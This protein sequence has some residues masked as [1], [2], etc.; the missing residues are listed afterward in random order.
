MKT[1]PSALILVNRIVRKLKAKRPAAQ[2]YDVY[3]KRINALLSAAS[4]LLRSLPEES[5]TRKSASF[6]KAVE[7]VFAY[8]F[9]R[10]Y[11]DEYARELLPYIDNAEFVSNVVL[12]D[13]QLNYHGKGTWLTGAVLHQYYDKMSRID[14]KFELLHGSMSEWFET[15]SGNQQSEILLQRLNIPMGDLRKSSYNNAI[16][17]SGNI[18]REAV[19]Y[20]NEAAVLKL[21]AKRIE[22]IKIWRFFF[23]DEISFD[24]KSEEG[25]RLEKIAQ[26]FNP[27]RWIVHEISESNPEEERQCYGE[28]A[29]L[30]PLEYGIGQI[31]AYFGE[32]V[33]PQDEIRKLMAIALSEDDTEKAAFY[34]QFIN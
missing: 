28:G 27:E 33:I 19:Y 3:H 1:P 18:C 17:Y 26:Y 6:Q 15:L 21:A 29:W 10:G 23:S 20:S 16:Y 30:L 32:V 4:K 31:K 22:E 25:K 9:S 13:E 34:A 24:P 7:Q 12:Q 5:P 14:P 2:V 11:Q 8:A